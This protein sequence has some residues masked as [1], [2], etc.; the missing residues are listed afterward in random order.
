MLTTTQTLQDLLSS[1]FPQF[2]K[3][4]K[5]N[6]SFLDAL[7]V[8]LDW[9]EKL[10]LKNMQKWHHTQTFLKFEEWNLEW[11]VEQKMHH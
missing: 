1:K 11:I 7:C 5:S 9:K 6:Y 4:N 3:K 8:E 2:V 10:K